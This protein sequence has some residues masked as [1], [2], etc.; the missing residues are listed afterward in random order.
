MSIYT[1]DRADSLCM[2]LLSFTDSPFSAVFQRLI[3]AQ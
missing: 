1:R 3:G 2:I